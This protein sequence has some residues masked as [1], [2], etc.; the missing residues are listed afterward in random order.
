MK[1]AIIYTR[2]SKD[3]Q[4]TT[5]Q[6]NDL[7]KVEG[8]E[9]KKVFSENI[10]GFTKTT[11]ERKELQEALK[12]MKKNDI[13]VMMV[14]EVSRLGRRT[15]EVLNLIKELEDEG[16]AIYIHNL[17]T[18]LTKDDIYSK[19]VV[20]IM[21]DL[22]RMESE[23]LSQRVKSGIRNRKAKGLHTGR[24]INSQ[25]TQEKFLSKHKDVIK[26]IKNGNSVREV[27]KLTDTSPTTVMKVKKVLEAAA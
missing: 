21:A 1:K 4:I 8:F 25:E 12:Y 7:K 6:V 26:Y 3:D 11:S 2:V 20:T 5:R 16:I 17:G 18:T 24:K 15:V 27:A 19:L 23:T 13:E 14:H 9:V 10:S 22:A